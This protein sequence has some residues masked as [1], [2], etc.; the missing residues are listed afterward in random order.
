MVAIDLATRTLLWAHEYPQPRQADA[1]VLPNGMRVARNGAVGGGFG[2]DGGR[3]QRG[4]H[5]LDSA[6]ILAGGRVLLTPGESQELLCLD[7]RRGT[8]VW[9]LPRKDG[10]NNA[11]VDC[12]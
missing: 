7:L 5:W 6:P 4:G 9:R 3:E 10:V 2:G 12:R 11:Y 8:T 1:M